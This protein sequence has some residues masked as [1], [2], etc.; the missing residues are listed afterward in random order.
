MNGGLSLIVFLE[1]MFQLEQN[2]KILQQLL[3]YLMS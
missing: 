1:M 2:T 3:E